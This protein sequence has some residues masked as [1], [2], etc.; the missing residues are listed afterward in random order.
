MRHSQESL[1]KLLGITRLE[2]GEGIWNMTEATQDTLELIGSI[3]NYPAKLTHSIPD[4]A[5]A[6]D[7]DYI[8]GLLAS[9]EI[10]DF[11]PPLPGQLAV[12]A[13]Q[14]AAAGGRPRQSDSSGDSSGGTPTPSAQGCYTHGTTKARPG[15]KGQGWECGAWSENKEPWSKDGKLM[16]DGRT[17]FYC[18]SKWK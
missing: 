10:I 15:F 11:K 8:A 2:S 7:A 3:G 1:D 18:A 16:G 6:A 13:P 12:A 17:V 4:S 9:L 14:G 5:Y